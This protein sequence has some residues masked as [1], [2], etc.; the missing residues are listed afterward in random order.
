MYCETCGCS[1]KKHSQ[2]KGG[3][4]INIGG[5]GESN[6]LENNYLDPKNK[7]MQKFWKGGL[8]K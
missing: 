1:G 2:G 8:E 4:T 5:V 3:E 6:Y 7:N